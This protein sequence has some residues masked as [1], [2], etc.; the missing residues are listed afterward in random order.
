M[1]TLPSEG[2]I[3]LPGHK[4]Q[5]LANLR[6]PNLTQVD[7]I[8]HFWCQLLLL[9]TALPHLNTGGTVPEYSHSHNTETAGTEAATSHHTLSLIPPSDP[10]YPDT[11]NTH[12]DRAIIWP[13]PQ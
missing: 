5:K 2:G 9:R 10:V 13:L 11:E 3:R 6:H 1:F 8:R 4:L 12:P 7:T